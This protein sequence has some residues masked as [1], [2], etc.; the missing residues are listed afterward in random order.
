M[1][2]EAFAA[3]SQEFV[4]PSGDTEYTAVLRQEGGEI[5]QTQGSCPARCV[6]ET[7]SDQRGWRR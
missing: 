7:G 3:G 2:D 1:K 5:V 6:E 4:L